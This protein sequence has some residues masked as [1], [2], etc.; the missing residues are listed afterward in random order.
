MRNKYLLPFAI[1]SLMAALSG[2]GGESANV[3][4][5][6]YDSSTANGACSI[7]ATGCLGFALDYPLN[8]LN[9]TCSSDTKNSFVTSFDLNNGAATGACKVGDKI[10]FFIKGEKDKQISLGVLDLNKIARVSTSQLPR[11]TILDIASGMTS[12]TA[13]S[14]DPNDNTV[15]VAM[16]LVKILQALAKQNNNIVDSTDIQPLYITDQMR[17]DLEKMSESILSGKFVTAT[18]IDL[19]NLLKPWVNIS[20]ISD[21]EAFSTLSNLVTIANAGVYQ[22]EFSLFSTAGIVGSLLSGSDGLVGCNKTICNTEDSSTQHLFGHFMLITDRDGYTFGS[23]LQWRGAGVTNT[24]TIGGLNTK[25]ITGTKPIRMTANAQNHWINPVTKKI[26]QN[27]DFQ[28]DQVT[29][30]LSIYQGTLYNDYMIAGKEKFYKLLTGKTTVTTADEQ[31]YGLW[32][33]TIGS[34]NFKGTLD[35]YKIFPIT[36]LDKRVF[37]SI[38]NVGAGESYAFP[39]YAN[40]TFKFT[41]TSVADVVLGIVIDEKGNI[42]TNIKSGNTENDMSTASCDST[43]FN[44]STYMDG[45]GVQQY[46][47]GT[48]SRAFTNNKT[49]SLRMVLGNAALGKIDGALVGMNTN[50]K[51]SDTSETIVVGGALL[52]VGNLLNINSGS[53]AVTFNDSEGST[54]KWANSLASFQKVYNTNNATHT[55]QDTDLAK[56]SGGTLTFALAPCYSVHVK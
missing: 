44:S 34:E 54:V 8:G 16:R 38:N 15:K 1:T 21:T 9:F 41:D 46:R 55:S 40:L 27:Y 19:E 4:P 12:Q 17:V 2:C 31:D 28:V 20:G 29:T 43:Q 14:L 47:I 5:E 18:D 51:T 32:S 10:T 52:N 26:D 49:L 7:G 3:K 6:V 11:L 45:F 24:S 53:A 25:L 35:L 48:I 37:K 22:P 13:A 50:I 30:P 39:M 23:G 56:L 36:Y 42:R 33:Q